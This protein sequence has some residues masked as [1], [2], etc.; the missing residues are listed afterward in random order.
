M[1]LLSLDI[2]FDPDLPPEMQEP[3]RVARPKPWFPYDWKRGGV[4]LFGVLFRRKHVSNAG[5]RYDPYCGESWTANVGPIEF[6]Y[7]NIITCVVNLRWEGRD[8]YESR[9]YEFNDL[10]W[11]ARV[12]VNFLEDRYSWFEEN[13]LVEDPYGSLGYY[14]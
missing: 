5:P 4:V 1:K 8:L 11:F 12:V 13:E 14:E 3:R 9:G 7:S 6:E 2:N 10:R